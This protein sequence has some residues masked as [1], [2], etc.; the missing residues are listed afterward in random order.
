ML[1]REIKVLTAREIWRTEGFYEV[2]NQFD[3]TVQRALQLMKP[4]KDI[5]S[6]K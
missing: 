1:K 6:A 3:S 5:L 4:M 2:N